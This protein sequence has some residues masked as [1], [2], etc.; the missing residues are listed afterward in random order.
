MDSLTFNIIISLLLSLVSSLIW[1]GL[2]QLYNIGAKTQINYLLNNIRLCNYAYEKALNYK[3]YDLAIT[4]VEL[5]LQYLG[6]IWKVKRPL[7]YWGAKHLLFNTLLN[8]LFVI[9]SRFKYYYKGYDLATE[10]QVCCEEAKRHLFSVGY[11]LNRELES[12][13][14]I[15][16]ELLSDFNYHRFKS[17]NYILA[18]SHCFNLKPKDIGERKRMLIQLID[19]NAFLGSYSKHVAKKYQ[20]LNSG[21]L[22]RDKYSKIIN[23]INQAN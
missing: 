2:S 18:N 13:S 16:I 15:T 3:D 21:I 23:K 20:L 10:K 14:S 22:T 12:A 4:N 5:M 9:T 19:V 6:D 11:D 8:N 7:T 17:V 1:W